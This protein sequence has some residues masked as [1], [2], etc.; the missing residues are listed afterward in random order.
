M[1][2][3][4]L[5]CCLIGVVHV[6]AQQPVMLPAAVGRTDS[7]QV[8]ELFFAGLRDK[9]NDNLGKATQN[10][11]R[12]VDLD[13][14]NDAALFEMAALY[15]KQNKL[16]ESDFAIRR[17]LALNRNNVWY[18]KLSAELCK[19]KGNMTELV[20]VFNQLIRLSPDE[21]AYYFDRSNAF[22]LSGKTEEALKGYKEIE[23]KFGP[24]DALTQAMQRITLSKGDAKSE[25]ALSNVLKEEGGDVKSYLSLSGILLDK[26]RVAEAMEKLKK[27]KQLDPDNFEVDLAMADVYQEQ[28]DQTGATEALKNAFKNPQMPLQEKVKILMMLWPDLNNPNVMRQALDL[29]GVL[30]DFSDNDPAVLKVYG[31]LL[32]RQGNL[33]AAE[34]KYLQS[35]KLNDQQYTVWEQVINL[36]TMQSR[37]AEAIKTGD[38]ALSI[39]PNQARLYYY[40][41]FALHRNGQKKEAL[42]N[43]RTAQ[44]LD[45][46]NADLQAMILVLQSEIMIDEQKFAAANAAF[47]KA[48]ALAPGNF[49]IMNNYAYYL[50]LRNQSLTKAEGLI[51][52]AAAAW[53]KNASVADTYALV[54]LKLNKLDQAKIWIERAI[55]NNVGDHDVYLEHYGDILFLM[56]DADQALVQWGKAKAAGNDSEKLSKK[57][58]DKKYIK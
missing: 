8:R 55:E 50:A 3:G 15:Y 19:R 38:E 40:Y 25:E 10:F 9:L 54:L 47:D 27:A 34:A 35:L 22:Y 41:A 52:K 58:N 5:F 44:Q 23:K 36:Q 42:E 30:L 6:Y 1:K 14:K 49:Q 32:Y 11:S 12:I 48:V 31:D 29:G 37:Y 7:N 45:S 24:S 4:L 39:Y 46:D 20:D 57:I 18:W 17:A 16:E 43:I 51:K 21:D 28:K 26:G 53:P 56:G 2:K 33:S 13:P